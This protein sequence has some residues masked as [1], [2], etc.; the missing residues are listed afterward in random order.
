MLVVIRGSVEEHEQAYILVPDNSFSNRLSLIMRRSERFE[1]LQREETAI[2]I[3]RHARRLEVRFSGADVVKHTR[4]SPGTRTEN[5]RML[6]EQL[7]RDD[8]S[9]E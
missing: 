9:Y 8:L 5:S 4:K 6:R 1:R 2:D 3:E 7:L